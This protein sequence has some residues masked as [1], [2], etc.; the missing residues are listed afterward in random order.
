MKSDEKFS[1]FF[2]KDLLQRAKNFMIA[3]S[4]T[5]GQCSLNNVRSQRRFDKPI[6]DAQN[7]IFFCKLVTDEELVPQADLLPLA[8]TLF[9]I[10][11]AYALIFRSAGDY[12]L[13]HDLMKA[14]LTH[15][16]IIESRLAD[17][18][19]KPE[20]MKE[21]FN[22]E[23]LSILA[24]N[25]DMSAEKLN[26]RQKIALELITRVVKLQERLVM[27]FSADVVLTF[28]V[29]DSLRAALK[30]SN[31]IEQ[32]KAFTAFMG[33]IKFKALLASK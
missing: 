26:T 17:F 31:V 25:F 5:K 13:T 8:K 28:E 22:C 12:D 1:A 9:D 27:D 15:M 4:T 29:S 7:L 30:M 2:I 3:V 16:V 32:G 14:L 20:L 24:A 11:L 6:L 33:K 10:L 23:L 18:A 21:F 19:T